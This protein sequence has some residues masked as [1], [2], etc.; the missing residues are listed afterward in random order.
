MRAAERGLD[1]GP[2]CQRCPA[3][4]VLGRVRVRR[5]EPGGEELLRQ[6]W[7]LAVELGELQRT[8][9]TAAARAEAAWLAGDHAAVR[10]IAG[11]AYEEARRLGYAPLQ[12][13]LG[14]WLTKAGQAVRR[15]PPSIPTPCR[16]PGAGGRRRRP[17]RRP[18]ARTSTPRPWPRAPTR[19]TGW[20]RWPSWT[21]WGPRRWPG[22]SGP[23]CAGWASPTFPADRS[24]ATRQNPAGLT[25]RQVQVLGLLGQ[26]CTNAE[27]ADRLVISTRT[28]DSHVA[29]VLAKLGVATR[30]AAAAR[31]ADL[32][33]L[34]PEAR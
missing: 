4:T 9:P 23:G 18:G 5:G 32:G 30:R 33:V 34:A 12:A 17:G 15:S 26:G 28:V 29:A 3:L 27:I 24:G 16:R 1:G 14:Y 10:A 8:G 2:P 22:W 6:A 13:E 20:P 11:P 31:A 25:E 7:E 19:R 21:P